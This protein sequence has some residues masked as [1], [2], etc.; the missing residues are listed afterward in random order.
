MAR[1]PIFKGQQD[2]YVATR[3]IQ[4]VGDT[5]IEPGELIPEG[6]RR[7]TLRR[8]FTIGSIGPVSSPWTEHLLARRQRRLEE[9]KKAK[10]LH[11]GGEADLARIAKAIEG[12][13]PRAAYQP[14]PMGAKLG[15][16][17][18]V[19]PTKPAAKGRKGADG[20]PPPTT[21]S[22]TFGGPPTA[23]ASELAPAPASE[24]E[25][26]P[27]REG[28]SDAEPERQPEG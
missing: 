26:A 8:W 6:I 24:L 10:R 1:R 17:Q 18:G 9:D 13:P 7:A 11:P 27:A 23:P 19:S 2:R 3:R 25:P 28:V 21:P 5:F 12:K 22:G 15:G 14:A 20:A 16:A 4:I